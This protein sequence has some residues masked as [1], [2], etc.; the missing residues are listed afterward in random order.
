M[1]RGILKAQ[2]KITSMSV[3]AYMPIIILK[4]NGNCRRRSE[5]VEQF[6]SLSIDSN[7][8]S[9]SC[10]SSPMV[11]GQVRFIENH[12]GAA[13]K[14]TCLQRKKLADERAWL[15]IQ[16]SSILSQAKESVVDMAYFFSQSL[17]LRFLFLPSI[18]PIIS[19]PKLC[20]KKNLLYVVIAF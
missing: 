13:R 19:F 3:L 9:R 8:E 2:L 16:Q 17:C 10:S 15:E 5:A 6:Q 1:R 14:V 18:V 20:P 7:P 12:K 4:S 11:E